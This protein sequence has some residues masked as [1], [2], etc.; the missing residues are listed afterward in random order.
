MGS[1]TVGVVAAKLGRNFVG[2]DLNAEYVEMAAKR[3]QWTVPRATV[4]VFNT[5]QKGKQPDS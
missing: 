2:V 3:I 4:Q 1:G 5:L